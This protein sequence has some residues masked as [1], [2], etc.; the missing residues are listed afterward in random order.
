[1]ATNEEKIRNAFGDSPLALLSALAMDYERQ[2]GILRKSQ[3]SIS[4]LVLVLNC[5]NLVLIV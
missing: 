4:V 2:A 1:M 5:P 3:L